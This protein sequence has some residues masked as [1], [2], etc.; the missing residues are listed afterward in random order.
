MPRFAT[1]LAAALVSLASLT[2]PAALAAQSPAQVVTQAATPADTDAADRPTLSASPAVGSLVRV[3]FPAPSANA[4]R[5]R[6]EGTLVM[7]ERDSLRVFW[8]TGDSSTTIALA[9]VHRLEVSLGRRRQVL[10]SIGMGTVIGAGSFALLAAVSHDD[11]CPSTGCGFLYFTRGEAATLA[12]V[13]GAL[14]GA[15]VGGIVGAVRTTE[16]WHTVSRGGTGRIAVTPQLGRS[17]GV[18][19]RIA[20]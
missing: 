18:R 3:T 12:G 13:M 17:N 16:R 7:L 6:F 9:D 11:S 2:G 20:F 10:R 14:G 4:R 1:S 5:P 8:Q 15:V 19:V